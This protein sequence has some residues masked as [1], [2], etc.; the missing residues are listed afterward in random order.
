M[1]IHYEIKTDKSLVCIAFKGVL[2]ADLI[3][4]GIKAVL[5]DPLYENNMAKLVD[6][7]EAK[8]NSGLE[9]HLLHDALKNFREV[10]TKMAI[11]SEDAV[12]LAKSMIFLKNREGYNRVFS[13]YKNAEAW[14]LG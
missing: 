7:R 10:K 9:V 11:V 12:T 4:S 8:A 3:F 2:S 13:E 5:D 1:S 14:L 6:L